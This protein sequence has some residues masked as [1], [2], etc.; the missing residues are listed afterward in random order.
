MGPMSETCTERMSIIEHH[1]RHG[2]DYKDS[3]LVYHYVELYFITSF[4]RFL[5]GFMCSVT[6][7][8]VV[9]VLQFTAK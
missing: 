7:R 2:Y 6:V 8:G 9:F 4:M 5:G 3:T 1:A